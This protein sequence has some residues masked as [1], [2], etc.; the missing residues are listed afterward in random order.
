MFIRKYEYG[1]D[2]AVIAAIY[3]VMRVTNTE[4]IT[5]MFTNSVSTGNTRA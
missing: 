4:K 2:I 3:Y 5:R 1:D